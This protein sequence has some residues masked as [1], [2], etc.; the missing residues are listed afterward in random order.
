MFAS[1]FFLLIII[2]TD[3]ISLD[4]VGLYGDFQLITAEVRT[5]YTLL[6]TI[7]FNGTC[8]SSCKCQHCILWSFATRFVHTH[9]IFVRTF[10]FL[11]SFDDNVTIV[12][13]CEREGFAQCS[14][15]F[16]GSKSLQ[17]LIQYFR[18][19]SDLRLIQT[20]GMPYQTI[21]ESMISQVLTVLIRIVVLSLG[22]M[23]QC[24]AE[25]MII[26]FIPAIFTVIHNRNTITAVTIG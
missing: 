8:N 18:L 11:Q 20:T 9:H 14:G 4:T 23:K 21:S 17:T 22:C 12:R 2:E 15:M 10:R 7:C 19:L 1:Q 24:Q 3:F 13:R 26:R 5:S 6:R 16:L 25:C